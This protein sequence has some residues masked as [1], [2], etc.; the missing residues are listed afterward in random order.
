M[1]IL[2]TTTAATSGSAIGD[3]TTP[4]SLACKMNCCNCRLYTGETPPIISP[5]QIFIFISFFL[6]NTYPH[7]ARGKFFFRPAGTVHRTCS[8]ESNRWWGRNKVIPNQI[9]GNSQHHELSRHCRV[10][11][12]RQNVVKVCRL[13]QHLL[14]HQE[15]WAS[16]KP[17]LGTY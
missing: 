6:V 3:F 10:D 2:P 8:T 12:R 17:K 9:K 5:E 1:N 16:H 15:L 4:S 7:T 13:D 11:Q 14:A